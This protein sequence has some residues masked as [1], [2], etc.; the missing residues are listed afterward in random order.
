M[1]ELR[2]DP[3]EV[4]AVEG[5]LRAYSIFVA[6]AIALAYGQSTPTALT[7]LGYESD[8]NALDFFRVPSL[9]LA[10]AGL[11]SAILNGVALAPGK[12][13]SSFVWALKGLFGGPLAVKQLRELDELKTIGELEGQ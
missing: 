6:I 10:V 3:F 13:R 7:M 8:N 12:K 2:K 4:L 9:A 11:G 1:G 5:T